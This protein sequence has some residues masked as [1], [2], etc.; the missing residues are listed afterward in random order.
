MRALQE[1]EA[2]NAAEHSNIVSQETALTQ[3]SQS[4]SDADAIP[5]AQDTADVEEVDDVESKEAT[6]INEEKRGSQDERESQSSGGES[7]GDESEQTS[8]VSGDSS[9]SCKRTL[10]NCD[11]ELYYSPAMQR[12]HKNW[13][14]FEKYVKEYQE[15]RLTMLSISETTNVRIRNDSIAKMKRHVGKPHVELPLVPKSMDPYK[16]V[17]I[18]THGW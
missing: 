2:R 12:Y 3:D 14:K 7:I 10:P 17:Y 1:E 6:D 5:C 11:D 4:A 9:A 15:D 16:R 8:G 13:K 18:C